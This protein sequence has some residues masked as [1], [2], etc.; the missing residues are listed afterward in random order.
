MHGATYN[1]TTVLK[2]LQYTV[3][4]WACENRKYEIGPL[5]QTFMIHNFSLSYLLSWNFLPVLEI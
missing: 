3:C 4:D 1:A 5:F 2:V